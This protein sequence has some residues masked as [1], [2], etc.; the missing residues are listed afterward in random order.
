MKEGVEDVVFLTMNFFTDDNPWIGAAILVVAL[1]T[2]LFTLTRFGLLAM[3]VMFYFFAL[4]SFPLTSDL[5]AWRA[6]ATIVPL[7]TMI[8]IA[9]YACYL[10]MAGRPLFS[11]DL[12]DD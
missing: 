7:A 2:V 6:G 5:T 10:A 3:T 4:M 12:L 1:A 9:G 8:G 11:G